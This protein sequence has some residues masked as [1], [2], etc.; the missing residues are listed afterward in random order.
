LLLALLKLFRSLLKDFENPD[1]YALYNDSKS[2]YAIVE[3]KFVFSLVWSFGASADTANR[4]KIETEI[5]KILSGSIP[6]EGYDKKRVS[7]PDRNS[8]FDYNY[9][10]KRGSQPG[11][12]YEW[13]LWTDYID[14]N[15]KIPKSALPQ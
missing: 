6:V 3:G 1:Y 8:L 15:E 10:E 13:I 7:F 2:R 11:S 12:G 9:T 5:K 14:L 4:K